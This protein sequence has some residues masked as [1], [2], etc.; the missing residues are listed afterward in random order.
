LK[1]HKVFLILLRARLCQRGENIEIST[2]LW[3]KL[4]TAQ[5]QTVFCDWKLYFWDVTWFYW[6]VAFKVCLSQNLVGYLVSFYP[7]C[8]LY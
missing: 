5:R 3:Y 6:Q 7:W 2:A 1:S 4:S 8:L